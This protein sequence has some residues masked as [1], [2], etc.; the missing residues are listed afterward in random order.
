MTR[1][2]STVRWL[3]IVV[4]AA[5]GA[6]AAATLVAH[7]GAPERSPATT[8]TV[9]AVVERRPLESTVI[10]RAS[11]V[12]V[13]EVQVVAPPRA[14]GQTSSVVTGAPLHTGSAVVPGQMLVEVNGRPIIGLALAVPLYRDIGPGASGPDVASLQ[15]ALTTLGFDA[16]AAEAG[17]F[18]PG[19]QAAVRA[20][21][22]SVGA[23]AAYVAGSEAAFRAGLVEADQAI[24]DA[25]TAANRSRS[26]GTADPA[27]DAAVTAA[28]AERDA[29]EA[30]QGIELRAGEVARVDQDRSV[31]VGAAPGVGETVAPGSALLTVSAPQPQA[32]VDLTDAQAAAITKESS[33]AL[34]GPAFS[35]PC[36]PGALL[37]DAVDPAQDEPATTSDIEGSGAP[38]DPAAD[39]GSA[40]AATTAAIALTCHPAPSMDDVGSGYTATLRTPVAG[41]GLVVPATAVATT[42]EGTGFVQRAVG[43]GRFERVPVEIRAEDAGFVA[44]NA[45][46]LHEGDRVRVRRG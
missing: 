1:R 37:A 28:E 18:G 20:L 45:D 13:D 3:A 35:A 41:P 10:A 11:V 33:V 25:L 40:G 36:T 4:V 6:A 26:E 12:N 42:A 34:S 31:V 2:G 27:L 16:P 43:N 7:R 5:A 29:Y 14:E 24:D 9:T 32:R 17:S 8:S 39:G 19:S 15:A 44:I 22:E 23:E 21:F 46:A 38:E 30:T